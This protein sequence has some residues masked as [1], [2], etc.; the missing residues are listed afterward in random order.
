MN[1]LGE[2]R[3]LLFPFPLFVSLHRRELKAIHVGF[4]PPPKGKGGHRHF[5]FQK[6]TIFLPRGLP[7]FL[8]AAMGSLPLFPPVGASVLS[9]VVF[10]S[11][12]L[13]LDLPL[14]PTSTRLPAPGETLFFSLPLNAEWLN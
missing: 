14:Y 11:F 1:K 8:Q 4:S 2:K 9:H 6:R 7:P 5:L 13:A 3:A 12:F 10:S